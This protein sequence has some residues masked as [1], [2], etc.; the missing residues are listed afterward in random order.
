[1][2]PVAS[3]AIQQKSC[4]AEGIAIMK[5]IAVKKLLPTSGTLAANMWWTH[6]PNERKPVAMSERTMA[7]Y[8][9]IGRRA[10]VGTI[11]EMNAR[12]G[13]KMM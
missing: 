11:A 4:M 1:M 8:P 3:V 13:M 7:S 5:L 9:N 2:R 12:P 6:S 10:N